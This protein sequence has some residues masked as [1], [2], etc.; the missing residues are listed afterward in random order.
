MRKFVMDCDTGTD[1]AVAL[2]AAFYSP[3]LELL[4]ITSVN[5][6]VTEDNVARNNLN[7]CEYLGQDIPV[8]RGAVLPLL[9]GYRNADSATHGA[10]GLGT[11]ELP[12][13]KTMKFCDKIASEFLYEK[14][15]ECNG[16]LELL[17]TG[18][19]TNIAIAI[20][21]YPDFPKLIKHMWF[22]GGAIKGGN[23]SPSAEFNIWVDPEA[24]HTVF[25][26]G[27]PL[28]MVG[29]DVTERAVMI[30]DDINELR[31]HGSKASNLSADLLDFMSRRRGR[32][33]EDLLMHD[34]TALAAAL[35]PQCLTF[36][37]Y[38]VDAEC[39]G[40]YTR[41]HTFA[42]VR[43]R[44]NRTPNVSVAVDIDT[45]AFRRWLVDR[46]NSCD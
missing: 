32:G 24:A 39:K 13:A 7:I 27:I 1:D 22:M 26:S 4:G 33:G 29:L 41:G 19:M 16:E 37:D 12:D 36:K 34:A 3:E 38:W 10:T 40:E 28:T 42:D 46:I 9:S 14:A 21:Q 20:I 23:S 30:R 5:G 44:L 6:N 15:K 17:V 8:C 35:Y 11:V 45:P 2:M 18:P 43:N 25:M 31:A